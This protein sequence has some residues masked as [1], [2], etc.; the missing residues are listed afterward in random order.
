MVD[1]MADNFDEQDWSTRNANFEYLMFEKNILFKNIPK[2]QDLKIKKY[3]RSIKSFLFSRSGV[4]ISET[5]WVWRTLIIEK[6][7]VNI[8]KVIRTIYISC[9]IEYVKRG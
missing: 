3:G 5:Y 8:V 9:V 2:K 7:D 1:T 4:F 6:Q